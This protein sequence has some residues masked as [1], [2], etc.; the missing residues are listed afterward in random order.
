MPDPVRFHPCYEPLK[1]TLIRTVLIAVA[2]GTIFS[3]ILLRHLPRSLVDG[4]A[5]LTLVLSIL[6]ISLGGHW[7]ELGYLNVLRPRIA[8]L[9][10]WLLFVVRLGVWLLGGTV[11]CLVAITTGTLMTTGHL[12]TEAIVECTLRYGGMAF[13]AIELV[14]HLVLTMRGRPS[15]WNLRG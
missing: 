7:L 14:P 10:D 2:L 11:L 6:W 9:P 13:I 8:R 4:Y 1:T 5:V 15:F 12:P 3:I